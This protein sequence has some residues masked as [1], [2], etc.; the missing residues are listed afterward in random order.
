MYDAFK[1][2]LSIKLK[3]SELNKALELSNGLKDKDFVYIEEYLQCMKL[4]A[5]T[6]DVL[7]E[8][9]IYYGQLLS[10]LIS[11]RRKITS[12]ETVKFKYVKPL[13]TSLV[14][15]VELRFEDI[16]EFRTSAAKKSSNCS[17]FPSRI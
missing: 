5:Q 6:L 12:L 8:E 3:S 14:I 4:L 17:I 1:Q 9:D 13:V 2:I 10:A 16:L 11:L 15:S 7:Q